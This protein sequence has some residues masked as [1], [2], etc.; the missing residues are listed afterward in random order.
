MFHT[1]SL[2][3]TAELPFTFNTT[4]VPANTASFNPQPCDLLPELRAPETSLTGKWATPIREAAK[5]LHVA[6]LV[7]DLNSK[8]YCRF[9]NG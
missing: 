3:Y 7:T 4:P 6:V 1:R 9:T 2:V 8:N 5:E